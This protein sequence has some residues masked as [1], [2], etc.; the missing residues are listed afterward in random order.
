MDICRGSQ[1][2]RLPC[3][4]LMRWGVGEPQAGDVETA[5]RCR[6]CTTREWRST[7][8]I[9]VDR[10]CSKVVIFSIQYLA[11]PIYRSLALLSHMNMSMLSQG[12]ALHQITCL[13][14]LPFISNSESRRSH[15]RRRTAIHL[16]SPYASSSQ[17]C[18]S[19][20]YASRRPE[21]RCGEDHGGIT[22]SRNYPLAH[23]S[24]P[25]THPP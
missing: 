21:T 5:S 25:T 17:P 14:L 16:E 22:H 4:Y 11:C 8:P 2:P 19:L 24:S 13:N 20:T 1:S 9:R 7:R 6:C 12:L 15:R 3:G 23:S 18:P 10:G